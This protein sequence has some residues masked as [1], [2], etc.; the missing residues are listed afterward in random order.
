MR[1]IAVTWGFHD[2]ERL[3][4]AGADQ[5]VNAPEELLDLNLNLAGTAGTHS[6]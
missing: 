2:R 4:A 5:L 6:D 1:V 3:L